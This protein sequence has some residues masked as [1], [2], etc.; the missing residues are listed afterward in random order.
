MTQKISR[1]KAMLALALNFFVLP[2]LG[3]I[4]GKQKKKGLIQMGLMV[5]VFFFLIILFFNVVYAYQFNYN[6]VLYYIGSALIILVYFGTWIWGIV[7]GIMMVRQAKKF[8]ESRVD[9]ADAAERDRNSII[10]YDRALRAMIV[11][12]F[13]L[14]GLGTIIGGRKKEGF[15]QIGGI[16]VI[17]IPLILFILPEIWYL[18]VVLVFFLYVQILLAIYFALPLLQNLGTLNLYEGILLAL[19]LVYVCVWIWA[20][21]SGIMMVRQAKKFTESRVDV[22]DAAERDRNGI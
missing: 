1:D 2:G 12:F 3:T 5:T 9:V 18:P 6:N 13:I 19:I 11:N 7:S 4:I 14:P 22:A 17:L 20:G 16:F 15:V 8:T 10:S 21:V